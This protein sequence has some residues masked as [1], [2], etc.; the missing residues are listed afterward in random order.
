MTRLTTLACFALVAAL[1]AAAVGVFLTIRD[2]SQ[3]PSRVSQAENSVGN[4][5]P[6]PDSA[7]VAVQQAEE[8]ARPKAH[9]IPVGLFGQCQNTE[10]FCLSHWQ[11]FRGNEFVQVYGGAVKN[12]ALRP[13]RGLLVVLVW[14]ARDLAK[15]RAR[16]LSAVRYSAPKG[17]G[18]L[19]ITKVRGPRLELESESGVTGSF[20]LVSRR[21]EFDA[22]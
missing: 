11:D 12:A 20:D 19:A 18:P 2:N 9:R 21:Y 8:Q 4:S 7:D 16:P 17:V 6:G 14:R 10:I 15:D 13:T 1:L 3:R 22:A 5:N